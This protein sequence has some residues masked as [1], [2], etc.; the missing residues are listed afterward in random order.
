MAR[1]IL[2]KALELI[3]GDDVTRQLR[4]PKNRPFKKMTERELL[5]L[6]SEIGGQ[7]FGPIPKGRRREFFCL[8][9]NTWIWHE[10]WIGK[11][12]QLE[13]STVRYEIQD[14]G[15]LKVQEGA[16]YS[17]LDGTELQNFAIAVRLYYER[18]VRDIYG[19][20]PVTGKKLV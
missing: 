13:T 19:H 6:E 20:D 15:V 9:E 3:V 7:L 11:N 1:S 10:E 2:K 14:G 16:K 12:R 5:R 4:M 8:D 18:V 17:Y